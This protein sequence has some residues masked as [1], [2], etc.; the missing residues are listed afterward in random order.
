MLGT[1]FIEESIF[2]DDRSEDEPVGKLF[3]LL[4]TWLDVADSAAAEAFGLVDAVTVISRPK[5]S[6]NL[7][8]GLSIERPP[9]RPGNPGKTCEGFDGR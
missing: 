6:G 3:E 5:F 1:C 4:L 7:L 2:S 8:S 9:G